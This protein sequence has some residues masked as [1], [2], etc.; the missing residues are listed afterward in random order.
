M[1]PDLSCDI[2]GFAL[3]S[4]YG[5]SFFTNCTFDRN[6]INSTSVTTSDIMGC[7]FQISNGDTIIDN[8]IFSNINININSNTGTTRILGG[9]LHFY[10]SNVNLTYCSF[11]NNIINSIE[12]D[13]FSFIG[14]IRSESDSNATFCNCNFLD[15]YCNT[16][17]CNRYYSYSLIIHSTCYM[18]M[19]NCNLNNNTI[20]SK[21]NDNSELRS[22][23][24][25][26]STSKDIILNQCIMKNNRLNETSDTICEIQS[27]FI[28]LIDTKG[29]IS[30]V[31]FEN[32]HI[33]YI[34]VTNNL[35]VTSGMI[36]FKNA[37]LII[38]SLEVNSDISSFNVNYNEA[39]SFYIELSYIEFNK[40]IFN[41][42][43]NDQVRY[44]DAYYLYYMN[45]YILKMNHC[46]FNM[47]YETANNYYFGIIYLEITGNNE[48]INEF[49]NNMVFFSKDQNDII[50]IGDID[51][52]A[53]S[54]W[55]MNG[56]CILPYEEKYFIDNDIE[57]KNENND[58]ISF[59]NAFIE[60]CSLL[61]KPSSPFS[62]SNKFSKTIEFSNSDTFSKSKEFSESNTFTRSDYLYLINTFS[63]I[64][65]TTIQKG[66]NSIISS[67]TLSYIRSV[68]FSYSYDSKAGEYVYLPYIIYSLTPSYVQSYFFIAS[69]EKKISPQK[70]IGIS[71][72]SAAFFFF[73]IGLV[74]LIIK[75]KNENKTFLD[76]EFSS[77]SDVDETNVNVVNEIK[78]D[79]NSI[80]MD[81]WL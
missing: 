21:N 71:C 38:S 54:K 50:F 26:Q 53:T 5:Q 24:I 42:K 59:Q 80:N 40:C 20:N 44:C 77:E 23:L 33:S 68:T 28:S 22:V 55:K 61:I 13:R 45:T 60:E 37:N 75:K 72:G 15:N 52:S 81:N 64:Q 25:S 2:R 34:D 73:I 66:K 49:T 3:Y 74:I 67:I 65:T 30:M 11:E 18:M 35:I 69:I 46:I 14:L 17:S 7:E 6:N 41:L 51:I 32:N 76:E 39:I 29:N 27:G 16:Q 56:N 47:E 70:M 36:Y 79:M 19:N 63:P 9:T 43:S 78:T 58:I 10:N 57:L 8:C 62:H 31:F 1:I 4:T 12:N 48:Y